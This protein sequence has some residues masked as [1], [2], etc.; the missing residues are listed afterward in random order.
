MIAYD[1]LAQ[2]YDALTYDVPYADIL[3][4]WETI[5][6]ARSKRPQRVLDLAC[7]TG[8]LSFLLA[9]H[10]YAVTAADCSER[11]LTEEEIESER[12]EE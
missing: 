12:S 6:Q 10:G 9:A 8:S 1:A 5:L 2:A 4:F 3:A 11:M 7:G